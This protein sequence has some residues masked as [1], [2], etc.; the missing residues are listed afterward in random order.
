MNADQ[1]YG[2]YAKYK[3]CLLKIGE[4]Q[5]KLLRCEYPQKNCPADYSVEC[6]IGTFEEMLNKKRLLAMGYDR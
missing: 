6:G 1:K 3:Y 4:D 2:R 5:Y